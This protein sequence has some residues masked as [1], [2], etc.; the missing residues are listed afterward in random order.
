PKPYSRSFVVHLDSWYAQSH[1]DED[2]AETFAVWLTPD[3]DWRERFKGWPARKKLEYVDGLMKEIAG[4]PPVV[5]TRRKVDPV[6][7]MRKTLGEHYARKRKHYGVERPNFYDRDLRR[8]FSDA[9]DFRG[10]MKASRFIARI[11]RDVR[12]RVAEATGEYQYTI[13]Q[14]IEDMIRRANELNL[15]LKV[16][17]EKASLD[18]VI[19]LTVQTMNY[20]H[21]GRHR[22]AL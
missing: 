22:V 21:S 10:N 16:S 11:K 15:R 14:V 18:F 7:T 9:P 20:L 8:L 6:H 12:R 19:L 2:F 13:D 3:G 17:E 4:K 1:P 5:R